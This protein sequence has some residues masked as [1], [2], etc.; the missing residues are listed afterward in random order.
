[1]SNI[2]IDIEKTPEQWDHRA[3]RKLIEQGS[4]GHQ[5][6]REEVEAGRGEPRLRKGQARRQEGSRQ[7]RGRAHEQEGRGHRD[8][9]QAEGRDPRRDHETDRLAEAHDPKL[10]VD[11]GE[12]RRAQDRIVEERIERTHVQ[13]LRHGMANQTIYAQVGEQLHQQL[14]VRAREPEVTRKD[15]VVVAIE[16]W[17]EVT[18]SQN[19]KTH[20]QNQQTEDQATE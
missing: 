9:P 8:D 7:A 16:Q 1:M 4:Q 11:P 13:D 15:A 18:D 10:R 3:N 19:Q 17:L 2:A 6:R 5:N 20:S 12:E 14:A